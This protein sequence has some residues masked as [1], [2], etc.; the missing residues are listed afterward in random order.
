MM[1]T[2]NFF[3]AETAGQKSSLGYSPIIVRTGSTRHTSELA[4]FD[5]VR[6]IVIRDGS[7]FVDG[8]FG[9]ESVAVGRIMVLG[10]NVCCRT[11]PEGHV[12]ST[13]IYIDPDYL[14]DQMFWQYSHVLHDRL[15]AKELFAMLYSE[16]A[17]V[18]KLVE[19]RVG[20][21]MPWL[22]EMAMLSTKDNIRGHFLRKH[23]GSRS[24]TP[25]P[26]TCTSRQS[27]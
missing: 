13:V 2:G 11:E 21:L 1:V 17:Q 18:L 9:K 23:S 14:A 10:A 5:C 20:M 16:P 22:D 15:D 24:P 3:P 4:A 12:T 26:R 6:V 19:E 25:S 7:A 8:E 27:R